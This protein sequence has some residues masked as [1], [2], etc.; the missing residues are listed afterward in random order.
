MLLYE[1]ILRICNRK[2]VH[3]LQV[4]DSC[5]VRVMIEGAPYILGLFD[6]AG[7]RFSQK[8]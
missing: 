2:C 5:T 4:F 1:I 6:T 8:Y 7:T 3:L